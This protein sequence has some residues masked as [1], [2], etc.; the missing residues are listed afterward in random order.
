M[1][2]VN[3]IMQV[4]AEAVQRFADKLAKPVRFELFE[5]EDNAPTVLIRAPKS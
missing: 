5:R 1:A 2:I 4:A 3:D